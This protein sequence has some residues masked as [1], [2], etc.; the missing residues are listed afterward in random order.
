MPSLIAVRLSSRHTFFKFS[1]D[2]LVWQRDAAAFYSLGTLRYKDAVV[3][4]TS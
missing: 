1:D 2:R 4:R 3:S